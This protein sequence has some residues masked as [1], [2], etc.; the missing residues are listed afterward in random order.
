MGDDLW[1]LTRTDR[2]IILLSRSSPWPS[3]SIHKRRC[4]YAFGRQTI[5]GI[6]FS[7]LG[8]ATFGLVAAP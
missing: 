3:C 1:S 7:A 2:E 5:D 8:F 4:A 6:F